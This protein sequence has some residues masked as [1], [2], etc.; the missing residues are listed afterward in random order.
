MPV[1]VTVKVCPAT[2]SVPVLADVPVSGATVKPTVAAPCPLAPL[3]TEIQLTL[4]AAVHEQAAPALTATVPFVA[5]VD[6]TVTAAG[7]IEGLQATP[8]CVTV[9]V[10]PPIV[11][12][13]VL[14]VVPVY[15]ATE[16][17]TVPLPWPLAP[18]V[19]VIQAAPLA[20]VQAQ[21]PAELTVTLPVPPAGATV[22]LAGATE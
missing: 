21:P 9:K 4:L 14:D 1:W 6:G 13:P 12:V 17:P 8:F 7:A 10:R 15:A 2:V 16:Y 11:S 22:V 20:A 3:V 18:L 19:T 5:P